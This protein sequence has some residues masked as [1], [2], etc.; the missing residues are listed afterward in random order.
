MTRKRFLKLRF[1]LTIALRTW[2]KENGYPDYTKDTK[3]MRPVSGKP[4]VNFDGLG[5]KSYA[6]C[7]NMM[8]D[9][10]KVIGMEG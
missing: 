10:R 4:L 8:N 2:A 5:V 6:E 3:A 1:A 9:L 7:W